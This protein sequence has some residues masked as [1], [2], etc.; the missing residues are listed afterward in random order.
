MVLENEI[1]NTYKSKI[2]NK[3]ILIKNNGSASFKKKCKQ[4][5]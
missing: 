2:T 5:Y 3:V 4:S 1:D